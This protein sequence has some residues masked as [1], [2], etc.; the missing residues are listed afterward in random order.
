MLVR[1]SALFILVPIV[2][3][4]IFLQVGDWL[5]TWPTVGLILLTG[6]VGAALAKSQGARVL[7]AIRGEMSAGRVPAGHLLDGLLILVGGILLLTPGLLTDIVG[8]LLLLPLTRNRVKSA[9][10]A[11]ME[12]MVRS[13]E[14]KYSV[15]MR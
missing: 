15:L 6:L 1:L 10:R 12:R 4:A 8:L 7:R 2:E 3:I 5:G 9:L 13:G 14:V 11:R